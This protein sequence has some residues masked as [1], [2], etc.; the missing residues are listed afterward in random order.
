VT[1]FDLVLGVKLLRRILESVEPDER[2]L[3]FLSTPGEGKLVV[4][5]KSFQGATWKEVARIEGG[6]F[7]FSEPEVVTA[8][9]AYL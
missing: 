5:S 1:E 9:G 3:R 8:K 7:R 6:R 2:M 4:Q